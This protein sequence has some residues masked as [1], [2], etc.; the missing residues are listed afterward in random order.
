MVIGPISTGPARIQ[1]VTRTSKIRKVERESA[2]GDKAIISK[3]ARKAQELE[4]D[5]RIA[6]K[7]INSSVE[8]RED[9]VSLAKERL[10]SGFYESGSVKEVLAERL[11]EIL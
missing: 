5:K 4:K 7:A 9:K 10:K 1:E 8:I 2:P 3:E 6:L 11:G